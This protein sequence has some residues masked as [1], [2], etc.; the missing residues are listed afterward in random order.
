MLCLL[1][2]ALAS[3]SLT[4]QAPDPEDTIAAYV[5]AWS[6][7]DPIKRDALL[8]LS[9]ADDGIYQDDDFRYEGREALAEGITA[10]HT[11]FPGASVVLASGIEVH[12]GHFRFRWDFLDA[13]GNVQGEGMDFGDLD[14][15]GRIVK[16]VGFAGPFPDP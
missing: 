2:T 14:A 12:H 11:R 13:D 15:E 16:L 8:E 5:E 3:M 1:M 7:P 9:W 6:E 4:A 10:F